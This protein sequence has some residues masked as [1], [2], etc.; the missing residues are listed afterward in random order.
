MTLESKRWPR[1]RR[2]DNVMSLILLVLLL[3][4]LLSFLLW[5][6]IL[7]SLFRGMLSVSSLA[8]PSLEVTA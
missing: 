7:F 5:L 1:S 4:L 6:S 2:E 3:F 8:D